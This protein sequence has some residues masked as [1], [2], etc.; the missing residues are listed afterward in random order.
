M[1][2]KTRKHKTI[3]KKLREIIW[4][5]YIGK[6]KGMSVCFCCRKS[7]ITQMNFQCGHIISE[8]NNGT[9]DIENLLPI[10]CLCNSSMGTTNMDEFMKKY[11]IGNLEKKGNIVI[12][13]N[14][15]EPQI[16]NDIIRKLNNPT[17]YICDICEYETKYK[18]HINDHINSKRHIK[19]NAKNN[20]MIHEMNK[21]AID[22]NN[23]ITESYYKNDLFNM[24]EPL[25]ISIQVKENETV[26]DILIKEN[27]EEKVKKYIC[28]HCT[29]DFSKASNLSRHIQQCI[30]KDSKIKPT[31]KQLE[32]LECPVCELQCSL[33]RTYLRHIH[34]CIIKKNKSMTDEENN[35]EII[36]LTYEKKIVE[37]KLKAK[38]E[39]NNILTKQHKNTHI[40]DI[41]NI[42]NIN[43]II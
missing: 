34:I 29:L 42:C 1:E 3:P 17:L 14:N 35:R 31:K 25:K 4:N 18:S 40:I 5:T 36:K 30:I 10:C 21:K 16:N 39:I 43:G 32:D 2:S 23:K 11:N 9:T 6:D 41:S 38:E 12:I 37:E 20:D 13:K 28:K 22:E 15:P 26:K 8:Y 33:K 19:N 27:N 24:Q 7:E